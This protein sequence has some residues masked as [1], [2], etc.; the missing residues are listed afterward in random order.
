MSVCADKNCRP[1]TGCDLGEELHNCPNWRAAAKRSHKSE[2]GVDRSEDSSSVLPWSGNAFGIEA[3]SYIAGRS[4]PSIVAI[5]GPYN[6]GK[7]TLL[8]S[9]YLL[10]SR[11][12][13]PNGLH[14]SGSFTLG[15]W[16]NISHRLLWSADGGPTFPLHTPVGGRTAGMLHLAYRAASTGTLKDYAFVDAPGEWYRR[17][18]IAEDAPNAEGARWAAT[19]ADVFL[20]L[21]DSDSLTGE[22]RGE[23]RQ[24]LQHILDRLGSVLNGR[25]MALVW[26]KADKAPSTEMRQAIRDAARLASSKYVEFEVSVYPETEEELVSQRFLSVL[27]WALTQGRRQVEPSPCSLQKTNALGSYGRSVCR[28]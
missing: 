12:L 2:T 1:E 27:E 11:G 18:S 23:A 6:S 24:T 3:I 4:N 28:A 16:E 8:A 26:S 13:F 21:A 7:T 9:W 15:G 14:F 17:W 25:P 19:N 10:T 20:V 22:D 5:V